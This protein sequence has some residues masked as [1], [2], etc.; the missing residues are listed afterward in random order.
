MLLK[1]IKTVYHKELD[2]LY[3]KEEVAS[4]FYIV[5][6]YYLNLERFVLAVQPN[7]I[8][9]KE[10]EQP[11]F[12]ALS[13]LKLQRP[14]QYIIGKTNFME[15]DFVVNE[16]VLIPRPETEA[17]VRW[18]IEYV[19]EVKCETRRKKRAKET[20]TSKVAAL[21]ILDIG[22]GSGCIAITLAKNLPNTKV[23]ALDVSENALSIAQN[24][25]LRNDVSLEF[26]PADIL[27]LTG[28]EDA[29]DVIVSNPP[30]VRES[31]KKE[32]QSNV[33]D[34]EPGLALFVP[35]D[36]PLLFYKKI[37]EF[38]ENNLNKKGSLFLEINQY[39][40]EET[41]SL[42]KTTIWNEIQLRKDMY[43]NDRMLM[44][45]LK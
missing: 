22:T 10:E 11:L 16:T 44:G 25:A 23:F 5:I 30:Y 35:D 27:R 20:V 36:D 1:E 2:A 42:L 19:R 26:I 41:K 40:G 8:I 18:V 6:E 45:T 17:L 33:L 13:Q 21:Q 4:F 28:L 31:E 37:V 12:E 14:I 38:A 24:N 9:S 34:H 7:I 3:A 15:L 39:L 43:G 32:I 29:F